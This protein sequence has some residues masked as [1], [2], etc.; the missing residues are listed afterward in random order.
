MPATDHNSVDYTIHSLVYNRI[1][2]LL[3]NPSTD[4]LISNFIVETAYEAQPCFKVTGV[5]GVEGSYDKFQ[6]SILADMVAVAMLKR[7]VAQN[8]QSVSTAG[9]TGNFLKRAKAGSAEAEF[10]QI[11]VDKTV[12]KDTLLIKASS[13]IDLYVGDIARKYGV[14]GCAYYVQGSSD[15][16]GFI[17][18]TYE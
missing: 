14:L 15:A 1:A 6:Q 7:I 9:A 18:T 12:A 3:S 4:G 8:S 10:E 17:V 16:I 11:D 13:L 2:F 5:V